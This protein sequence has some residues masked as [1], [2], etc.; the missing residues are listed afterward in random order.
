MAEL[1]RLV[2]SS[3][4]LLYKHAFQSD[5]NMVAEVVQSGEEV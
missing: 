1:V 2:R 4:A 3:L 5:T